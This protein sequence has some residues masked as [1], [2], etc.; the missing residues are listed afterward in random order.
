[1][2][3]CIEKNFTIRTLTMISLLA[4]TEICLS[5]FC[6]I[7][8]WNIKI[9]FNFMPIIIAAIMF[10]PL[11]AGIV[12]A[13]ADFIGA[14]LF[15]IG[16]YF[17]GFTLTAFLTGLSFGIFL[18]KKQSAVRILGAV[19]INQLLLSLL[20]NTLWISILYASPYG[21]VLVTRI[22]Q[23]TILGPVQFLLIRVITKHQGQLWFNAIKK[24]SIS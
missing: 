4:A 9:K 2:N 7:S 13:L 20:L 23:C 24:K 1:M 16:P 10:G 12:A 5:R 14:I 6:S 22:I 21:A 11:K 17:P 19:A 8:Y 3:A 15:P 18:Y